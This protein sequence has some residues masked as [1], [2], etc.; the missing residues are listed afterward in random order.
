MSIIIQLIQA[1]IAIIG[2]SAE[3]KKDPSIPLSIKNLNIFGRSLILLIICLFIIGILAAK[4]ESD[5][6][7]K[8]K[9]ELQSY[10]D[11]LISETTNLKLKINKLNE[12][13]AVVKMI[14][15]D[16]VIDERIKNINSD[17]GYVRELINALPKDE[18]YDAINQLINIGEPTLTILNEEQYQNTRNI[19]FVK[20][21]IDEKII[22]DH[23]TGTLIP[24][25][26]KSIEFDT[27]GH[28][29][30]STSII[31]AIT[32]NLHYED[33]KRVAKFIT[34]Y[35]TSRNQDDIGNEQVLM[36]TILEILGEP[37]IEYIL[38]HI[39]SKDEGIRTTFQ[40]VT[41]KITKLHYVDSAQ[42]VNELDKALEA[43]DS[44][45]ALFALKNINTKQS[46]NIYT[47]YK[48]KYYPEGIE[49]SSM[50]Y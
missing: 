39:N 28:K 14:S 27:L 3:T 9:N 48:T 13:M 10:N 33:S 11:K 8:E 31:L 41:A 32:K 2:V 37:V 50:I 1:T 43:G 21:L 38:P 5:T 46:L 30:D 40:H 49:P 22:S 18:S 17:E 4:K 42:L 16:K 29:Y 20:K 15:Y 26:I 34:H 6:K 35:I 47:K 24:E 19:S 23:N 25:L 45:P 7:D 12:H 44:L 36:L